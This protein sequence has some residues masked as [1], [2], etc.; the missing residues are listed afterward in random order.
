M[1]ICPRPK[2]F[3][4]I[5]EIN[6]SPK[7]KGT[8]FRRYV[9]PITQKHEALTPPPQKKAEIYICWHSAYSLQQSGVQILCLLWY[10]TPSEIAHQLSPCVS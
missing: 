2:V 3:T 6:L 9:I 7:F 10:K 5:R 4:L 8:M 1:L